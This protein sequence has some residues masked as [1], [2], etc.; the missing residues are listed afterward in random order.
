MAFGKGSTK[1]WRNLYIVYYAMSVY[2]VITLST[3]HE[4]FSLWFQ[5]ELQA[6][7]A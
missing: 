3:L 2:T 5:G 6:V 1:V 7:F 4:T